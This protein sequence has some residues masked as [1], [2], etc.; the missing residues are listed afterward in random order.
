MIPVY[1][2]YYYSK[3]YAAAI[4][5][6]LGTSQEGLNYWKKIPEPEKALYLSG[7]GQVLGQS[8]GQNSGDFFI[9]NTLHWGPTAV[10]GFKTFVATYKDQL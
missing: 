2:H 4:Y 3:A 1:T 6:A 10:E 7:F 8:Q 9:E 5:T